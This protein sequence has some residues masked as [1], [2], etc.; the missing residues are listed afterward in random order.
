MSNPIDELKKL[1]F[2]SP[3]YVDERKLF[4][5]AILYLAEEVEKLKRESGITVTAT[6]YSDLWSIEK[7]KEGAEWLKNNWQSGSP[8]FLIDQ[9]FGLT[10][11]QKEPPKD[12][13]VEAL[14]RITT[15]FVLTAIPDKTPLGITDF[16]NCKIG[17]AQAIATELRKDPNRWFEAHFIPAEGIGLSGDFKV[18]AK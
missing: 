13:L 18:R 15:D 12:E 7:R 2:N 8:T 1:D 11:P 9:A 16:Y 4:K 3:V 5:D 6:E 17:I 14:E 10:E